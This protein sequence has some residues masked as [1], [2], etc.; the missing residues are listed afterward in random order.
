MNDEKTLKECQ[1]QLFIGMFFLSMTAAF[2]ICGFGN[3][4]DEAYRRGILSCVLLVP[5]WIFLRNM[6]KNQERYEKILIPAWV[7]FGITMVTVLLSS[8]INTYFWWIGGS[9]LLTALFPT[10]AGMGFSL[11]FGCL[12][13]VTASAEISYEVFAF[14]LGI[15]LC[16]S[17]SFLKKE[18]PLILVILVDLILYTSLFFVMTK[19]RRAYFELPSLFAMAGIV[20]ELAAAK[21]FYDRIFLWEEK[22]LAKVVKG[23]FPL[24]ISLQQYSKPLCVHCVDV[25]EL[26]FRAAKL[27]GC[28]ERLCRAGGLY[29]EAGQILGEAPENCISGSITLMKKYHF[30]KNVLLLMQQL[31]PAYGLPDKKEAVIV[32]LTDKVLTSIDY[33]EKRKKKNSEMV[34]KLLDRLF[35]KK[36]QEGVFESAGFSEEEIAA[37]K[38]FY[39]ENSF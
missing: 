20:V 2:V 35:E 23:E 34:K 30:P 7:I 33:L 1:D 25:S 4:W 18:K 17:V 22:M 19:G 32:G 3:Q 10:A 9:V 11:L 6:D 37:L 27:L 38:K 39:L 21:L 13:C 5:L 14:L 26:S 29:H 8:G 28:D 24:L 31:D 36:Q 16:G 12:F 15:F